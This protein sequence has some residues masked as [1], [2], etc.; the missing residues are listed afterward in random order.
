MPKRYYCDFC[1]MH[2]T[3]G[4][5]GARH[6]H[7]IGYKHRENVIAW[8]NQFVPQF[9]NSPEGVAWQAWFNASRVGQEFQFPPLPEGWIVK[10]DPSQQNRPYFVHSESGTTQW[11]HPLLG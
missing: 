10:K 8:Y 4:S 6:Q 1:D 5:A 7:N 9:M 3:K 11:N 2:L